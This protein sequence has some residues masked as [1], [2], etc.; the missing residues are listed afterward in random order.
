MANWLTSGHVEQ[1]S[2]RIRVE[3]RL[4]VYSSSHGARIS[5][6]KLTAW[7]NFYFILFELNYCNHNEKEHLIQTRTNIAQLECLR[8]YLGG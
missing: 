7:T 1:I 3:F 6:A 5:N 8:S 4:D 2:Y